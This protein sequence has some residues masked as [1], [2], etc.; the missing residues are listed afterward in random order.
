MLEKLSEI[1]GVS[2]FCS[3]VREFL[4][5][6]IKSGEVSVDN[7]GNIIVYKKG[8]AS[9]KKVMF[10]AHMDEV[11]FMVTKITDGGY[12]K[13]TSC[14]GIDERVIVSKRVLIGDNKIPG[15]I[16]YKAVH[17]QKKDERTKRVEE[18]NLSIDI[19]AKN[20]E[21]AEKKVSVGDYITFDTKFSYFGDGFMKGKALDDRAGC[22]VLLELL[23][24]DYPYDFYGVFSTCEE[25]GG[26]GARAAAKKIKPDM[27][28]VLEGTTCSD[29]YGCD[30]RDYV[31]KL[32]D[33]VAIP[34]RDRS[35][36]ANRNLVDFLIHLANENGI[37]WQ[38]K[39][40]IS[41]GTDGGAIHLSSGGIPTAIL[42][43][44][45]RYIHSPVGVASVSDYEAFLNLAEIFADKVKGELL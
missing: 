10:C 6:N 13:F 17:L 43:L 18:K 44:P 21:E 29:V 40:S 32:K 11:G 35:M 31:T 34:V 19:G 45:V 2:G 14:G 8:Q 26:I 33:G 3:P 23:K 16:G 20:K 5:D 42:A 28:L 24:K 1:S 9:D 41:G 36:I 22:A 27:A 4:L 30:E 12:I 15:V 25:I 37:K 7:L 39:K 38:Y